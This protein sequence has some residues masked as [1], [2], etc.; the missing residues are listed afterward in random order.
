VVWTFR[1]EVVVGWG[2]EWK[3]SFH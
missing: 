2:G 1:P 3:Q